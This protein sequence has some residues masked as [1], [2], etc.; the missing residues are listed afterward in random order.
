MEI[1]TSRQQIDGA[2]AMAA[3]LHQSDE[4]CIQISSVDDGSK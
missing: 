1:V 2:A 3:D 4:M